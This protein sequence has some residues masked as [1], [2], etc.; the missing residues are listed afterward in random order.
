M[1]RGEVVTV[2]ATGDYGSGST[3]TGTRLFGGFEIGCGLNC[4]AAFQIQAE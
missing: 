3:A 2:A 4:D 1:K